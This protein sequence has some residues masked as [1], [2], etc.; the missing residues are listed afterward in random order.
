MYKI[1]IEEVTEQIVPE[2]EYREMPGEKNEEGEKVYRYVDVDKKQTVSKPIFSQL[3]ATL[4][5]T[6]VIK[7]INDL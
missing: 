3:V 5:F 4:D 7:A 6:A 1:T 2:R